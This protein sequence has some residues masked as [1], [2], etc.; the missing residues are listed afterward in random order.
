MAGGGRG[1]GAAREGAGVSGRRFR[2]RPE[3]LQKWRQIRPASWAHGLSAND[4]KLIGIG[5]TRSVHVLLCSSNVM[6]GFES[7][8]VQR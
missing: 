4:L 1:E 7:V 2:R 5:R 8:C 3:T 6:G